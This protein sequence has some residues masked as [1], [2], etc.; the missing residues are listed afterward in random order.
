MGAVLANG[1]KATVT[2]ADGR[3][4]SRQSLH[5]ENAFR[6]VSEWAQKQQ[7]FADSRGFAI[8]VMIT[9]ITGKRIDTE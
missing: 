6:N 1:F 8:T 9:P 3:S 4:I 5:P 7:N 2:L